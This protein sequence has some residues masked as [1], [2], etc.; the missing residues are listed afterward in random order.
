MKITVKLLA[1]YRE[2]LPEGT[3]GNFCVVDLPDQSTV[4]EILTMFDI[5]SGKESVVLVN[6]LNSSLEQELH[7][8]DEVC[9]FSAMAGG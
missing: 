9:A 5:P 7:P 6:G 4:A 8:G 2:L 1:S 3:P